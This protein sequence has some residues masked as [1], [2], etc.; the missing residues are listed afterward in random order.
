MTDTGERGWS[1]EGWGAGEDGDGDG[2]VVSD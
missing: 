1:S 2:S